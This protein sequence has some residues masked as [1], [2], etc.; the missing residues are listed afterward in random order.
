MISGHSGYKITFKDNKVYK[1]S[2]KTES[3]Y[4]LLQ[5]ACKQNQY[6]Q[7]AYKN[8]IV[9]NIYSIK[10][11]IVEEE[12]VVQDLLTVEMEFVRG[13]DII[14]CIESTGAN[15]IQEILKVIINFLQFNVKKS[16]SATISYKIIDEK[17]AEVKNRISKRYYSTLDD[18]FDRFNGKDLNIP[19]GFCHG[20]LTLSNMLFTPTK[21]LVLIDFLDSFIESPLVDIAK[22]RQDT[23]HKWSC[24]KYKRPYDISKIY[25]TL[26]H[27][28]KKIVEYCSQYEWYN[29]YYQLFQFLNLVRIL[30]YCKKQETTDFV[31]REL[32][33]V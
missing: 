13:L 18:M 1:Q 28:D 24:F 4:R 33:Q 22:L 26:Q 7:I 15:Q 25:L 16:I 14:Q 17:Y 2:Q 21:E 31:M 27:M 19:I 5:Q 8:I 11:Q 9:P 6:S 32:C 12:G 10:T 20:D 29:K 23:L 30:P 3:N